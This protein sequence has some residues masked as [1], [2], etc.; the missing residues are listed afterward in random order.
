MEHGKQSKKANAAMHEIVL[1]LHNA[2]NLLQSLQEVKVE[3][4]LS[5]QTLI[6]WDF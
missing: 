3:L 5:T 2:V 6:Y 1:F 4:S